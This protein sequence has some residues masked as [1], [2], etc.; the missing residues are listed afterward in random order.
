[1]IR[2][3]LSAAVVA[4][5]V[6]AQAGADDAIDVIFINPGNE[7][8]F[9]GEVSDTMLAAAQD[10]DINLEIIH[11]HRDRIKMVN[12]AVELASREDKPDYAIIVNELLQGPLLMA[13]LEDAHIPTFELLNRLTDEQRADYLSSGR[14]MQQVVGSIVPDNEIAGYEMAWSLI[15]AARNAGKNVDGIT[16]LAL[17]GDAAT[18]A[19]LQREAGMRRA[20]DEA[21]DVT[22]VR[23]FPV[24]WSQ[25]TAYKRT[26]KMLSRVSLD[27]IWSA[28]DQISFGAQ[29]AAR[30]AGLIPGEDTFFAGLNWSADG[31]EA[32]ANNQMTLTH[33]GHFFAGAWSMVLLRDIHD[34]RLA[35]G[36]H[37]EFP[38]SAVDRSNVEGFLKNFASRNWDDV[39]FSQFRCGSEG[40]ASYLFTTQSILSATGKAY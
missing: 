38:M 23:S 17:L 22:L 12:A 7:T 2:T 19:A 39:D 29:Q 13:A 31:L 37:V 16:M 15:K 5:S 10:L 26:A 20:L 14:T 8:Q 4:C 25:E 9:W 27:T 30:E 32:V 24:L 33:G 40:A 18:P 21:G 1:M 34:G 35:R 6:A 36:S 28:N 11:T 3:F